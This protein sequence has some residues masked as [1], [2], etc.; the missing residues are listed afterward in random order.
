MLASFQAFG[1]RASC[2]CCCCPFSDFYIHYRQ[3]IQPTLDF[4]LACNV[5][6]GSVEDTHLDGQ[7]TEVGVRES[8]HA[9]QL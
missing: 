5:P 7:V 4:K 9:Q 8:K 1:N 6:L 2:C 3:R